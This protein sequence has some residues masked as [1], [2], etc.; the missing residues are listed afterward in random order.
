MT[1]ARVP[2]IVQE[3]GQDITL[4]IGGAL[5]DGDLLSN[6]KTFVES[7]KSSSAS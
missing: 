6:T 4:L 1:V 7:V 5:H 3:F 2:E